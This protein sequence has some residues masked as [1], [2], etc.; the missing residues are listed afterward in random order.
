MEKIAK[1]DRAIMPQ[2]L[3]DL[4]SGEFIANTPDGILTVTVVVLQN[5]K[6]AT[7]SHK[8]V[9]VKITNEDGTKFSEITLNTGSNDVPY[10]W[11]EFFE[12]IPRTSN[13]GN[14]LGYVLKCDLAKGND[15]ISFSQ[16]KSDYVVGKKTIAL[17][18]G[19]EGFKVEGNM[20]YNDESH[21]IT[22]GINTITNSLY[23]LVN[24]ID[25]DK[26]IKNLVGE[27]VNLKIDEDMD[28]IA[29]IKKYNNALVL[30]FEDFADKAKDQ[31]HN[32]KRQLS[33]LLSQLKLPVPSIVP[34]FK[35][36]IPKLKEMAIVYQIGISALDGDYHNPE[37]VAAIMRAADEY[38]KQQENAQIQAEIERLQGKLK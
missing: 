38:K 30:A 28:V 23:L 36:S 13:L 4:P 3:C 8:H 31:V 27:S 15:T 6:E 17:S 14:S 20:L 21:E 26:A 11:N 18:N 32:N 10:G 25:C 1:I 16:S 5:A 7:W 12:K 33:A 37:T 29:T 34:D 2:K 24:R 9:K 22:L 19:R 35:K